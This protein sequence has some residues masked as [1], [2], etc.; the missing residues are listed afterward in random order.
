MKKVLI[1]TYYWPP[2]GGPGVQRI[3]NFVKY[4]PENGW[5][6]VVLTVKSGEYPEIDTTLLNEVPTEIPIFRTSTAEPYTFYRWLV[7]GEK[8]EK[9]PTFVLTESEDENLLRK[10]S[11]II[12]GN[13]FIPDA[14]IGWRP[15]AVKK[16]KE[17]FVSHD[18]S[19]VFSTSPP[20]TVNLIA[21]KISGQ[22][23][24]PWIAD[25][26]DPWTDIFYYHR[27]KRYE[28]AKK[29]DRYLE[30]TS[31]EKADSIITVSPFISR[32]LQ[33]KIVNRYHVIPNGFDHK[34]FIGKSPVENKSVFRI[35]HT[36][37]LA[38]NQNPE[39][40][41]D[42]LRSMILENTE[43]RENLKIEFYGRIHSD[44]KMMLETGKLKDHVHFHP[45]IPHN[46]VVE[47][48]MG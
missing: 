39:I 33:K 17:I 12:R 14:K 28:W 31:L 42:V 10:M 7:H 1:I 27:L 21:K 36:G 48:M 45:Y 5:Q 38:G 18:I 35:V 26:R 20:Q 46:Q 25:L 16:A 3:L 37:H 4:L 41:W 9:I 34:A 6:P 2:A 40:L 24:I 13:I 32:M 8:A 29:L 44:I 22:K 15:F 47:V 30:R 11:A 43:F 19:L 23:K